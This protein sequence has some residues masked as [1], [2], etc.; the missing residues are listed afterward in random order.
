MVNPA[1]LDIVL[2]VYCEHL[3]KLVLSRGVTDLTRSISVGNVGW[4]EKYEQI[5]SKPVVNLA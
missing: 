1:S 5:C 2:G 3:L 4:K